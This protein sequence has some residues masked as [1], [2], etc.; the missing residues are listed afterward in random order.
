MASSDDLVPNSATYAAVRRAIPGFERGDFISVVAALVWLDQQSDQDADTNMI[1]ISEELSF[2]LPFWVIISSPEINTL[3][4]MPGYT[5]D[6]AADTLH[7]DRLHELLMRPLEVVFIDPK[8]QCT[9]PVIGGLRRIV[10]VDKQLGQG[11]HAYTATL[12]GRPVRLGG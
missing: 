1:V 9:Y 4:R 12:S 5:N 8:N 3:L 10:A 6:R 7:Q 11:P 2:W